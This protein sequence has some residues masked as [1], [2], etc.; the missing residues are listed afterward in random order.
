M[1]CSLY[2]CVPVLLPSQHPVLFAIALKGDIVP[3]LLPP[4]AAEHP[5]SHNYNA[6]A[7]THIPVNGSSRCFLLLVTDSSLSRLD[8]NSPVEMIMHLVP[9]VG[10]LVC[11]AQGCTSSDPQNALMLS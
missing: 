3:V 10:S 2:L 5:Q 9:W 8:G 7:V 6:K 4:D 11:M 1:L